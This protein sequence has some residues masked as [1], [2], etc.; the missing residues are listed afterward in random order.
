M[1]GNGIFP[2]KVTSIFFLLN[3]HYLKDCE[4]RYETQEWKDY[5]KWLFTYIT[6][7]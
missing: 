3:I 6:N 7:Y 4:T 2:F 5:L 1:W